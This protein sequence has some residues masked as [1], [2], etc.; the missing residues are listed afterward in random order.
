MRVAGKTG[1]WGPFR[2]DSAVVTH[3]GETPI[4]VSILTRSMEFDRMLP[5]VDDGIGEIAAML[6][7]NVRSQLSV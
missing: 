4:A 3:D 1:S 7:D 2:H 5:A 6:V